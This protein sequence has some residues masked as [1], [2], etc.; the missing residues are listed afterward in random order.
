MKKFHNKYQIQQFHLKYYVLP[1]DLG[2]FNHISE[3]PC[4]NNFIST[5]SYTKAQQIKKEI[6]D[7]YR[8]GYLDRAHEEFSQK[9]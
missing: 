2:V 5:W 7:A 6:E 3:L 9:G 8:T 1:V 4:P